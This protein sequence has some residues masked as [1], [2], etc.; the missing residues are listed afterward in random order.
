[1][2]PLAAFVVLHQMETARIQA[3]NIPQYLLPNDHPLQEKIYSLFTDPKMFE[4][5][6]EL[7]KAGFELSPHYEEGFMVSWHPQLPG[8]VLKK[9][10]NSVSKNKQLENYVTRIKGAEALAALIQKENLKNIVTPKKWLYRLPDT[11]SDPISGEPSYVLIAER[12]HLL[13][14]K[15]N[16]KV[17]SSRV[18]KEIIE[19]LTTVLY[20][21]RGLDSNLGNM[22][23]TIDHQIAFI[24]TCKWENYR[25]TFL[26]VAR[27]FMQP[28]DIKYAEQCYQQLSNNH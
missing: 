17:Y 14:T 26:K 20:H 21:F 18:S 24:D 3:I 4:S 16:R 25:W 19:E 7:E 9:F 23:F 2:L 5:P 15:Q 12:M 6:L 11:F 8:Y 1:M 28:E 27:K 22:P 10:N 13:D